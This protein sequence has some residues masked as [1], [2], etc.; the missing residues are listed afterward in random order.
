MLPC[1]HD[2]L[3]YKPQR[4]ELTNNQCL[5]VPSANVFLP[6]CCFNN[7]QASAFI[8]DD[9]SHWNWQ[10]GPVSTNLLK[11]ERASDEEPSQATTSTTSS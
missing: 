1:N 9:T 10:K 8:S 4:P 6:A 11:E 3:A 7:R 5:Y 2:H